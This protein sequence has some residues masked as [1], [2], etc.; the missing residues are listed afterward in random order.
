MRRILT[1]VALAALL[2][3]GAG[4]AWAQA[5][6]SPAPALGPAAE[7]LQSWNGIGHKIIEMAE[8]LPEAKYSYRP[9]PVVR[10]FAELFLHIAG[11]NLLYVD[12]ARG[13]KSGPENL[14]SEKYKTKAEVVAVLKQSFADGAA[15]IQKAGD[16]HMNDP[17]KFPFGNRMINQ[18]GFWMAQVE[19]AGEHYGNLVTYFRL[20]G[21]VPPAS[22]RPE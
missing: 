7:V 5:Q 9:V 8:D 2:A 3:L 4:P 22:R 21:I 1:F 13:G 10:S 19:H 11:S 6:N 17:V 18:Y 12:T 14:S 20:N 16:A 15:L